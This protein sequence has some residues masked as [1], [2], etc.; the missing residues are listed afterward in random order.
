MKS[1]VKRILSLS[2]F[3]AILGLICAGILAIVN[4]ITSPI[5]EQ[6]KIKELEKQLSVI[7]IKD[8]KVVECDLIKGVDA[9]YSGIYNKG[10]SD[11]NECYIFQVTVKND[12]T[13]ITTIIAISKTNGKIIALSPLSGDPSYTTHGK[14]NDFKGND[15]GLVGSNNNGINSAFENVA[16]ATKSSESI[17]KAAK[18]AFE[19]YELLK[20]N[21]IT[22][23]EYASDGTYLAYKL[24]VNKNAP[25]VIYTTVTI[26]NDKLVHIEIDTVQ[27]TMTESIDQNGKTVYTPSFDS[28]SKRQKGYNYHMHW[29]SYSPTTSSPS[30]EGYIAWLKANNKLEWFEQMDVLEE[31]ILQNGTDSVNINSNNKFENVAGV[32]VTDYGYVELIK[33]AINNA[34]NGIVKSFTVKGKDVILASANIDNNGDLNNVV[35]DTIEGVVDGS[36]NFSWSEQTKNEKG[37]NYHMHWYSYLSTTSSSSEEGYIEWLKANNKLEWFE[38]AALI[39]KAWEEDHSI[40]ATNGKFDTINSVSISDALY[41]ETL[42]KLVSY[43]N[44]TSQYKH[45]GIYYAYKLSVNKNAPELI[46][47]KITIS[48]GLLIDIEIDTIQGTMT[49]SKDE[50]GKTVYTPSFDSESKRQKGYNYHMH[51]YS[52]SPTTSSPSEEGYIA[53][54]KANNKLEW[55]EQMDVL[56]EYILQNGTD[57]VN[58]NSNNKFENVAG[59]SVTDYGY[60]ELIKEAINNAKNGIVKSFTVKGKDVILASAN[61]DNNGD[62]NNV[63][64]DTIEGVVDGSGNFSWSEQTKNEKGYNYHMHW[65]SYLSTTSSSSE[66][67]YIEWLKANNKLEW[68]EQAAL[69]AKAWEEDHSIKATN[70][71]FDTINSVSIS[72]ALYI[73]TLNKL[74]KE[75]E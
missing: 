31:Y 34:K 43:Q 66:E 35:L 58:I 12:Y 17:K 5:I 74:L 27:G 16:G 28:E 8:P 2:L 26:R 3:L 70:G 48:D 63:V 60:V 65:Y 53:W 57:S 33:E 44:K 29:Y 45:D 73:E 6:N 64:L 11:E 24:N 61:I 41:I 22:N 15:F 30:E 19:Q 54:L 39:A 13:S 46:F 68:F 18:L 36:G 52:Y 71:K 4:N 72:D 38:Q 32:S 49:E 51:W 47:V 9:V 37:Y 14:N 67:G 55:F 25:E 7:N 10:L 1:D 42:N 50:N 69:I 75:R 62:L 59:V 23:R 20:S 40:K 21:V 56:E